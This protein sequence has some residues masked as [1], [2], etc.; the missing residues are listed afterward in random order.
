V[1]KAA[2]DSKHIDEVWVSTEDPKIKKVVLNLG[3]GIKVLDRPKEL[4]E[5]SS[6]T[7][8]VMLHFAKAVPFD[9][10]VTLQATS[11]ITT[12]ENIDQALEEFSEK[13]FDSLLT[14]VLSKSFIWTP[15]GKPLNYDPMRRPRRQD[16]TGS[17]VENGAF[18]ITKRKT[19]EETSCRLGGK[20]GIYKM[21][22]D[23]AIEIDEPKDFNVI[24][25]LLKRR[26]NV[27]SQLTD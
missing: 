9:I 8:S 14:G 16:W 26:K 1:L 20:I 10:L 15:E 12:G 7:E 21:P 17:I 6:S 27:S 3:L 25:K 19:L 18:Y 11:P 24:A 23:S 5:D 22:K 13:G 4:A 2:T